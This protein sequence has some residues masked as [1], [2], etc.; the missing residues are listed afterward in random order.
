MTLVNGKTY[1]HCKSRHHRIF[2][3]CI[4]L[5]ITLFIYINWQF[6]VFVD[7]AIVYWLEMVPSFVAG[8]LC[9]GILIL[10]SNTCCLSL[11]DFWIWKN[12]ILTQSKN[13]HPIFFVIRSFKLKIERKFLD[14]SKSGFFKFRKSN[15]KRRCIS[16]ELIPSNVLPSVRSSYLRCNKIMQWHAYVL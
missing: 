2:V 3:V 10:C 13:L 8:G 9:L 6:W 15:K 5:V 14:F 4:A 12:R 11:F 16:I 7:Y 1:V